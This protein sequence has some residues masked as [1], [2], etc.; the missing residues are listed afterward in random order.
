MY[1]IQDKHTESFDDSL[2]LFVNLCTHFYR[3]R[4]EGGP[5][6]PLF[7]LNFTKSEEDIFDMECGHW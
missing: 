7:I 4:E 6:R 1:M 5:G 2:I 3:I